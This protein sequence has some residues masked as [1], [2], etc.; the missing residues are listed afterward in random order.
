M[1]DENEMVTGNWNFKGTFVN[2]SKTNDD[3][4]NSSM[5][6][7]NKSRDGDPTNMVSEGDYLGEILFLGYID[8]FDAYKNAAEIRAIVDGTPGSGDMP[9]RLE[10]LTTPDGSATPA[11]RMAIDNAGNVKMGD[12]AWTNYVNIDNSGEMTFNGTASINEPTIYSRVTT[13]TTTATLTVAEAGT[14]L[15]SASSDYTITLPTAV[16]NKGLTYHFKKTDANYNCITLDGDGTET[17]NY[18][19]STSAPVQTYA[20]LNTYCAEATVV[21]DG[22]NWQVMDEKMGQVPMCKAYLDEDQTNI[23]VSTW[24]KVLLDAVDLDIDNNFDEVNSKYIIPIP[25]K[26]EIFAYIKYFQ[27]LADKY[28][29][30]GIRKNGSELAT[31]NTHSSTTNDVISSLYILASFSKDDYLESWAFQNGDSTAGI[32]GISV[33]TNF[34]IKLISKD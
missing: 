3:A 2:I 32:K 8:P 14:V 19:N 21:S 7:F 27:I 30:V 6:R 10:F 26:Y 33:A 5:L 1:L 16:G 13:K 9:G 31:S 18:E 23:T 15:V 12:G 25:G 11:L 34:Y 24:T 22:S 17:L 29:W 4:T 28:F 20:R